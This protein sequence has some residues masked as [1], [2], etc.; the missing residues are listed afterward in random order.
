MAANESYRVVQDDLRLEAQARLP[1]RC[2]GCGHIAVGLAHVAADVVDGRMTRDE[3]IYE[4]GE[5]A[6]DIE[7]KC[8][9][10]YIDSEMIAGLKKCSFDIDPKR[11]DPDYDRNPY[12]DYRFD[13]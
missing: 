9:L 1:E 5:A 3:A 13:V 7:Q 4:I 2:R 6:K 10:G 12:Y 8:V 11:L